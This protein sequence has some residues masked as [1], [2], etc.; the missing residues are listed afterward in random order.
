MLGS[1][2]S[3]EMKK[4]KIKTVEVCLVG[5]RDIHMSKFEVPCAVL[6]NHLFQVD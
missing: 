6:S 5:R 4:E 2:L 1:E 3:L